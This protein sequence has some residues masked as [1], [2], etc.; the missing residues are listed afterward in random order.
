MF[1]LWYIYIVWL[2]SESRSKVLRIYW[3]ILIGILGLRLGNVKV[4]NGLFEDCL[5][6][7]WNRSPFYPYS[8]ITH[9]L[10]NAHLLWHII[11]FLNIQPL[12]VQ[13][14]WLIHNTLYKIG[15]VVSVKIHFQ[16]ASRGCSKLL[17]NTRN[18]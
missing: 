12:E 11:H 1:L 14:F 8:K 3:I 15:L 10:I 13:W 16:V 18:N 17:Q 2:K 5:K 6:Q 4:W 7:S 9:V